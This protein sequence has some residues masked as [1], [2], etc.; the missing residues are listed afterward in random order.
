MCMSDI[1]QHGVGQPIFVKLV[2]RTWGWKTH[3]FGK[4]IP[5]RGH[6]QGFS[7][8]QTSTCFK[9]CL[10][11]KLGTQTNEPTIGPS[12]ST[13]SAIPSTNFTIRRGL[14]PSRV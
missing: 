7:R 12:Q 5:T 11:S 6:T 3:F 9:W 10:G 8:S 13:S 4:S 2:C 14:W 1:I